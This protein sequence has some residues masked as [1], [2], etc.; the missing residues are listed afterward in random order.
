MEQIKLIGDQTAV[1]ANLALIY[2]TLG[3]TIVS[4]IVIFLIQSYLFNRSISKLQKD[5]GSLP[6]ENDNLTALANHYIRINSN[7]TNSFHNIT[8]SYRYIYI[9]LR[10][11]VIELRKKD[12]KVTENECRKACND[13]EKFILSLLASLTSTLNVITQDECA[14][15]LKTV[16]NNKIKTLYRDPSSYRHRKYSD[17]NQKG[18]SFIYNIEDNYAFNL[19]ADKNSKETFF[20]CDDLRNHDRYKNINTEWNKLYNATIVVPIQANLSGAKRKKEMHIIGFLCC[21]NMSGGFE[22]KEIKDFISAT[23]DLLYNLLHLY[24]RFSQLASKKGF[25]NETLQEYDYWNDHR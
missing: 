2:K 4:L 22:N 23:G 10:D 1:Y 11:I 12:S 13:F 18:Q 5:L 8:H 3:M 24:D 16:K 15:C 6:L 17:Y 19:I 9:I 14:S 7:T 25:K 21:D 20:A